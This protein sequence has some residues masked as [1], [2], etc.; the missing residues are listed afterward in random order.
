MKKWFI[1]IVLF[2]FGLVVCYGFQQVSE[3]KVT[4][5]DDVFLFIG[6]AGQDSVVTHE[7]IKTQDTLKAFIIKDDKKE[8]I[9]IWGG[10]L[11]GQGV[12][13][14]GT[15]EK[16][17]ALSKSAKSIL[18]SKHNHGCN[19]VVQIGKTQESAFL[20]SMYFRIKHDK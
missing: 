6:D 15:I 17:G 7:Y 3:Q 4:H 19:V 5:P 9:K 8:P 1:G 10:K 13:G 12:S 11:Y 18:H 2:A 16:R 14:T 20:K